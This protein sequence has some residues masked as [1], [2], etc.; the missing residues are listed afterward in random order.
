MLGRLDDGSDDWDAIQLPGRRP[1]VFA[2]ST[3]C[4]NKYRSRAHSLGGRDVSE[5][6]VY[7]DRLAE[8]EAKT[9]RSV[10]EQPR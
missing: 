1:S 3:S 9:V 2:R 4:E 8:F 10:G 5:F 7:K 6:I